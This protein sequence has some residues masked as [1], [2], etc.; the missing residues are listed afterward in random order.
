MIFDFMIHLTFIHWQ[1]FIEKKPRTNDPVEKT[2]KRPLDSS[3]YPKKNS[4]GNNNW[5][6][7]EPRS[8]GVPIIVQNLN[9]ISDISCHIRSPTTFIMKK[10]EDEFIWID[11]G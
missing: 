6:E 3:K 10:L 7:P 11:N 9:F 8:F 2:N 1:T 4:K 5:P